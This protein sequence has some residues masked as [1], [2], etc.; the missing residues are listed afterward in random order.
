MALRPTWFTRWEVIPWIT[1]SSASHP[2]RSRMDICVLIY[3]TAVIR[4][5]QYRGQLEEFLEWMQ[6]NK[7]G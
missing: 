3:R 1:N 6:I 5:I 2:R 7:R 4:Y